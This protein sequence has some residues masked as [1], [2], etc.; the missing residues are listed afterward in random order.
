VSEA[1]AGAATAPRRLGLALL[2]V[3][4]C[5][6]APV[7]W[8]LTLDSPSLR[9]NGAAAWGLLGVALLLGA[10]AA[11]ADRRLV[12]QLLAALDVALVG[13]FGWLFFGL[14]ALHAQPVAD[15][16]RRAPD[17]TLPDQR[18]RPVS[19]GAELARGP[20]LLVFYRGHW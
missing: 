9:A 5:L 10:S 6:L 18:G 17:F 19:L 15:E 16:L 14:A 4:L 20:V 8:A 3:L 7:A 13:L 11:S 12:V 2:S 1:T